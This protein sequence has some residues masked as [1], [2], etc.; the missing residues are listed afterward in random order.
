MVNARKFSKSAC[1]GLIEY[2]L[3]MSL[4]FRIWIELLLLTDPGRRSLRWKIMHHTFDGSLF[5]SKGPPR[6]SSGP[7]DGVGGAARRL[8]DPLRGLR[9]AVER[10]SDG[11]ERRPS[12][13][14]LAVRRLFGSVDGSQRLVCKCPLFVFLRTTLLWR[15]CTHVYHGMRAC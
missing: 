8:G 15:I 12:K 13:D 11:V 4:S 10:T 5:P 14:L 9:R 1:G 6:R 3:S 7:L 2:K